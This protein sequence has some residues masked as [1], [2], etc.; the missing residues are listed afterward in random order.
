MLARGSKAFQWRSLGRHLVE[1]AGLGS[2]ARC[3]AFDVFA[4][5]QFIGALKAHAESEVVEPSIMIG[6]FVVCH[7]FY[8]CEES[9]NGSGVPNGGRPFLSGRARRWLHV[10]DQVAELV[11]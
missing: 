3:E 5:D 11:I 9:R 2:D 7:R 10:G 8:F 1:M 6:S 4:R